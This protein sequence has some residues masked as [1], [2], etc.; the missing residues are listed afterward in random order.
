MVDGS[1]IDVV[2]IPSEI[3]LL[4][5]PSKGSMNSPVIPY[6]NPTNG[7][8]RLA[9]ANLNN[10]LRASIDSRNPNKK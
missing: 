1:K 6:M 7:L 2:S 3:P 5:I 9:P 10:N 8:E 4:N